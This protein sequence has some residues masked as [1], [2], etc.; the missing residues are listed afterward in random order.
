QDAS[1][2]RGR[3]GDQSSSA[4][5]LTISSQHTNRLEGEDLSEAGRRPGPCPRDHRRPSIRARPAR[6]TISA[7]T[8][9]RSSPP[10]RLA[11]CPSLPLTAGRARI[12]AQPPLPSF[13]MPPRTGAGTATSRV[14]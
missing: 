3:D 7:P 5:E 2:D 13:K 9:P 11:A 10:P 6:A 14:P 4:A 12:S 1:E 8:P